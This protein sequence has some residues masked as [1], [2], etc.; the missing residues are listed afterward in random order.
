MRTCKRMAN[1]LSLTQAK[2]KFFQA[3]SDERAVQLEHKKLLVAHVDECIAKGKKEAYYIVPEVLTGPFPLFNVA[4]VALW[5]VRQSRKGGMDAKLLAVEPYTIRLRGWAVE[6]WL[7][8]DQPK[9]DVQID[10]GGRQRTINIAPKSAPARRAALPARGRTKT[11]AKKKTMTTEEVS[12]M[13]QRG[14]LSAR[15]KHRMSK[16]G[17]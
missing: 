7:D 1:E 8:Q 9:E 4:E 5:L 17:H 2:A 10:R 13:A 15:L 6:D 12:V 3:T 14:E 16:Y 11:K